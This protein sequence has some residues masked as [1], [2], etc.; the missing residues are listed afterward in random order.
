MQKIVAKFSFFSTSTQIAQDFHELILIKNEIIEILVK[1]VIKISNIAFERIFEIVFASVKIRKIYNINLKQFRFVDKLTII[2]IELE[3]EYYDRDALIQ[4]LRFDIRSLSFT[5]FI[6]DFELYRNMYRTLIE[7]YLTSTSLN[8]QDRQR[9][10]NVYLITLD[11]HDSIL[12]DVM[13]S[14]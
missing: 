12:N 10:K 6:D 7:I 5:C 1:D 9:I 11:S 2:R 4:K 14:L 3:I 13:R 8:F